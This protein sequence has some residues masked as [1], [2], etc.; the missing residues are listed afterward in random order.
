MEKEPRS[1]GTHDGS[2]H[3]DEVTA[4]ALLIIT[5]KIDRDKIHRSRDALVLDRCQYVADV[6]GIY[7]P[8]IKRF[9]HH[10]SDYRGNLSSAGMVLRYLKETK[11]LST[12]EFNMLQQTLVHGVDQHDN[13]IET[14]E[15]GTQTYSS[16]ISNFM[17]I[18]HEATKKELDKAFNMALDL[19]IGHLTRMRERF[20]Y[21]LSCKAEVEKAMRKGKD[22]LV[23]EKPM[24]WMDAFFELKGDDHPAQ[25]IIMPSGKHWKLRG[26]P[27]NMSN[28]MKVRRP[29][30]K[31]WAGL[32]GKDLKEASGIKGAIFCHKGQFISV[33]ETKEDALKALEVVQKRRK[34]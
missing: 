25:F 9:D 1:F 12:L 18:N 30:P 20:A 16:V 2:F 5:D 27:P 21:I 8:K 24:P 29:L 11:S 17:P 4:A 32:L 26:I 6:G 23:F 3:A 14:S 31:S 13:G 19:A 22:V 33:W 15:P 7:D 34:R 28:K 10:Q